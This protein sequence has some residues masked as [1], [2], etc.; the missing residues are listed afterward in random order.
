MV[1]KSSTTI[2]KGATL[3]VLQGH[4]PQFLGAS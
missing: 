3:T 1:Y 4:I 2:V